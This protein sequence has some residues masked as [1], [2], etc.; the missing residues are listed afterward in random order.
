MYVLEFL[1]STYLLLVGRLKL[2]A[3]MSNRVTSLLK[4]VILSN[5]HGWSEIMHMRER[6][7]GNNFQ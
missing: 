1:N 7:S 5:K 4:Q 3:G 2:I 6:D